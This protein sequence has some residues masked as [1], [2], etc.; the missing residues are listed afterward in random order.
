MR[1]HYIHT[2]LAVT[3][4][5]EIWSRIT[6]DLHEHSRDMS[7]AKSSDKNSSYNPETIYTMELF[8]VTCKKYAYTTC[9]YLRCRAS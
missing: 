6:S 3:H 9:S 2:R 7:S 1:T 8:D 5:A 4:N